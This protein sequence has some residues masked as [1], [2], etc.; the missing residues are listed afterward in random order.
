[1]RD[2]H[3]AWKF[4]DVQASET[5]QTSRTGSAGSHRRTRCLLD[6]QYRQPAAFRDIP[7][8]QRDGLR[9]V[10]TVQIFVTLPDEAVPVW[11]PVAAVHL[12]DNVYRISDQ[13]YDRDDERWEFE[14]GAVVLCELID[15]EDGNILAATR[16]AR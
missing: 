10:D 12:H 8:A 4:V 9:G 1:M 5:P 11:R 6:L 14:S 15:A 13:P 16:Q 2:S 3:L 7:L